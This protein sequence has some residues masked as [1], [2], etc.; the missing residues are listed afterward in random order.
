[1]ENVSFPFLL[2]TSLLYTSKRA[3]RRVASEF[4]FHC[5]EFGSNFYSCT[6][7]SF[8][9]ARP[10]SNHS[11]NLGREVLIFENSEMSSFLAVPAEIEKF[12]KYKS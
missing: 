4:V 11:H 6:K 8:R 5:L 2:L 10:L 7:L 9:R 3:S 1:M 12:N